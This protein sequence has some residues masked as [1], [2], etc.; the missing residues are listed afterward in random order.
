MRTNLYLRLALATV[1][2][3]AV[4]FIIHVYYGHGWAQ[5]Y[6]D[7]AYKAR[8]WTIFREPY[9]TAYFLTAAATEVFP[10]LGFVLLYLITQDR[11][12]GRS[13][14]AKGF[15]FGMLLMFCTD[16]L[17][18]LPLLSAIGGNPLDV[19]FVQGL[20]G[21]AIYPL[22][23]ITIAVVLGQTGVWRYLNPHAA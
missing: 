10:V 5:N 17:I 15:Y 7:R 21:W 20:E 16:H 18:R 12:P 4:L 8:P 9:P 2:A 3:A 22:V 11:L 6:V 1:L 14:V 13:I 19:V 23:G